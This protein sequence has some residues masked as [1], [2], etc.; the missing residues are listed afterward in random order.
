MKYLNTVGGMSLLEMMIALAISAALAAFA[1]TQ[2]R[3][4]LAK[5]RQ[6]LAY[7]ELLRI[8]QNRQTALLKNPSWSLQERQAYLDRLIK[9][10]TV[11]KDLTEHYRISAVHSDTQSH[12]TAQPKDPALPT[13]W[14]DDAG[15]GYLCQSPHITTDPTERADC[16]AIR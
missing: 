14:L 10:D 3:N 11:P 5:G 16:Q 1:L 9:H 13:V 8:H 2:Y 12:L 4:H 7:S 6:T 15:Y